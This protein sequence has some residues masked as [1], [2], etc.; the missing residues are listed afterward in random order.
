MSN[1]PGNESR[2]TRSLTSP[3]VVSEITHGLQEINTSLN[4]IRG[5]FASI[6]VDL[7]QVEGG[8]LLAEEWRKLR[9]V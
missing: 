2:K 4:T 5:D 6:E 1:T 9:E 7:D 8:K 3:E